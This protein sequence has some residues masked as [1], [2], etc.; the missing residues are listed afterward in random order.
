ME[1]CNSSRVHCINLHPVLILK[2]ELNKRWRRDEE[3]GRVSGRATMRE[4]ETKTSSNE[5]V[6]PSHVV[7]CW[8]LSSHPALLLKNDQYQY[9]LYINTV[10]SSVLNQKVGGEKEEDI[11][12][13]SVYS[14]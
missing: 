6:R 5:C 8:D 1:L 2:R 3:K 12:I 9:G 7:S 13:A 11:Y 4:R 10:C 14:D